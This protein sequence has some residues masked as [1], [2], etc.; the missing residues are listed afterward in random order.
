MNFLPFRISYSTTVL[1]LHNKV[2]AARRKSLPLSDERYI[3]QD[4]EQSQSGYGLVFY[5]PDISAV[6][7]SGIYVDM[8]IV[9][10]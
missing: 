2:E 10:V 4:V 5:R 3:L 9:S 1:S 8:D 6:R 7:E